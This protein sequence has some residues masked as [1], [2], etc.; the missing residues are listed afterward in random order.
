MIMLYLIVRVPNQ[1]QAQYSDMLTAV[2]PPHPPL[3][4]GA[5]GLAESSLL[6]SASSVRNKDWGLHSNVIHKGDIVGNL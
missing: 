6:V 3:N 1:I 4:N 2:D 5:L